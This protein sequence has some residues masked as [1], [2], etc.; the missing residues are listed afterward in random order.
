MTVSTTLDRKEYSGDGTSVDF[1]FPYRFLSTSDLVVILRAADGTETTQVEGTN[2]SVTG[3]D[4]DTGG[5]VT[6]VASPTVGQTL[7]IY[8]DPPETQDV[9]YIEGDKFPAETHERALDKLTM[10]IQRLAGR[11]S[12]ALSLRATDPTTGGSYDAQNNYIINVKDPVN[13]Q[14]ATT[15]NWVKTYVSGVISGAISIVVSTDYGTLLSGT[16]I[17]RRRGTTVEHSTFTGAVGEVTVDTTKKTVVA[18]DGAT[19]GGF[20]LVKEAG[21]AMTGR[22]ELAK[23]ADLA[24]AAALTLGTDGNVFH[25]TGI[26]TI[27]SIGAI[28]KAGPIFLVFDG[29]LT[30]THNATSLILPGG[31]NIVTAAG[32]IAEL[33]Q[34]SSGNWRCVM[35]TRGAGG[36]GGATLAT[37]TRM[38]FN[39]TA[40]PPGWTKDTTIQ[41]DALIRFT[42]GTASNNHGTTAFSSIFGAGKVT[43]SHTLTISEMPFHWHD[44][45]AGRLCASGS[46]LHA[47]YGLSGPYGP[48][49]TTATGGGSGH[50]H[51]LTMDIKYH[52]IIICQ[53]P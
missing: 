31:A 41:D 24:S 37:G 27:T 39:Q 53:A 22:L 51:P 25:V 34:E 26:T 50:T 15:I 6:M 14:D 20:A 5:T 8:R 21:S 11:V 10:L 30:L 40:A 44:I 32:D 1:A 23:G 52:D 9:D 12:R 13:N 38:L 45:Y 16:Q 48:T 29:A 46:A 49:N 7:V 33:V 47:D 3:V 42:T 43:G 17:K 35:Y 19:A 36:A 28:T 4:L 18:H 2:Y